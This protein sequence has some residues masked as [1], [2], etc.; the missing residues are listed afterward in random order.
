M[1]RKAL[2]V[3]VFAVLAGLLSVSERAIDRD[4]PTIILGD[5]R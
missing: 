3:L 4:H 5:M 1:L 2:I